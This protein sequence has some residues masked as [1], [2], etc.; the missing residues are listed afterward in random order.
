MTDISL[1]LPTFPTAPYAHLIAPLERAGISTSQ[2]LCATPSDIAK[3]A[4]VPPTAAAR[5]ID[6]VISALHESIVEKP[7]EEW[8]AI[9]FLDPV[10]DQAWNGGAPTRYL[11]EITGER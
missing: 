4:Q 6:A 9:S 1:I 3:Q 8:R 7:L 10:L 2:L 5:L 11:T